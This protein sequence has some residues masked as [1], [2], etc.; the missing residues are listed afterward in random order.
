MSLFGSF[1]W[2]RNLPEPELEVPCVGKGDDSE[3]GNGDRIV[4]DRR[5]SWDGWLSTWGQWG[6][7]LNFPS[8]DVEQVQLSEGNGGRESR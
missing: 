4:E 3:E 6:G 1:Q 5:G 8:K 2:P 7:S